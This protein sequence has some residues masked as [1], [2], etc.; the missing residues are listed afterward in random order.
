MQWSDTPRRS[1]LLALALTL[2][3]TS[4]AFAQQLPPFQPDGT[5]FVGV[6]MPT[7]RPVLGAAFGG[8]GSIVRFEVEYAGTRGTSPTRALR[9]HYRRE[10]HGPIQTDRSLSVPRDWRLRPL[11]RD[12]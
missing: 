12:V 10:P 8:G 5:V 6:T 2:S 7:A 1:V 4:V 11:R 9:R 3:S